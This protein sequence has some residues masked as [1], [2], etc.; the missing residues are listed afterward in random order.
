MKLLTIV[1]L[2]FA[3]VAIAAGP[4]GLGSLRIGVTKDA[5]ERIPATDQIH[6]TS[7]LQPHES[8]GEKPTPGI[9]RFKAMLATPFNAEP[10]ET[11]LTFEGEM[12]INLNISLNRLSRVFDQ[13]RGQIA[14]KYGAPNVVNTMTEE[15]CMYRSGANFK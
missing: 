7:P 14:E 8:T 9:E 12:L 13:M 3:N 1:L 2:V 4:E 5:I 11:I 10:L 15:Q 6:L